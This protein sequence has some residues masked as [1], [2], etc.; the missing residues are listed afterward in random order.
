MRRLL[1]PRWIAFHLVVLLAVATTVNLARWQWDRHQSRVAFNADVSARLLAAPEDLDSLL[2]RGLDAVEWRSAVAIGTYLEGYDL[3]VVNVSQDGRAGFDPVSALRLADGNIVLVKRGFL[4]LAAR[5]ASA[6]TGEVRVVGRIRASAVRR[7]GA[8]TD[9]DSG[10]LT[11]VQRL[12]LVR[13]APQFPG[14]L[15]GAYLELLSSEPA[16]DPALSRLPTPDLTTGPHLSYVGQWSIFSIAVVVGWVLV[17][18]R[19][20]RGV[21]PAG[22]NPR[23]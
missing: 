8:V 16:D 12:D 20:R 13:L 14:P 5:A 23:G 19:S 11:E 4:P 2:A 22:G 10:V 15:V 1:A 18:R 21:D 3:A 6:P 7:L 17:V 9:P